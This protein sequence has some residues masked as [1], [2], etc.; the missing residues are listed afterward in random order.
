MKI[1]TF[2]VDYWREKTGYD[3]DVIIPSTG[4]G[5]KREA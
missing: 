3:F 5:G 4:D 2:I 1:I